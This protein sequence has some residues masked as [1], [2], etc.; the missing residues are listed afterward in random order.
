MG[1]GVAHVMSQLAKAQA[2]DRHDVTV[3][4]SVR[5]DTPMALLPT[6]FPAPI[7]LKL[8]PMVTDVA[9]LAD[10]RSLMQ[11]Y[12]LLR[13]DAPD[14]IHLHSSKAG[15]LGRLAAFVLGKRRQVFYSPHAFAFLRE[16]VSPSRQQLFLYLE[17]FGSKLGGTLIGCSQTEV[18]LARHQVGHKRTVLVENSVDLGEVLPA[19]GSTDRRVRV[20]TSGRICYQKAPWR[21]KSLAR[22]C[23][24]LPVDFAWIGNG[25]SRQELMTEGALPDKVRVTRWLSRGGV[26]AEL[27]AADVFVL[28]SLWEG[29]P[30]ALIEAQ[31]AGLPAVVSDVA[32]NRDIV[33]DGQTGFVCQTD[34][35]FLQR[36][37]QLIED[38]AL[39]DSMGRAA[40][41]MAL[42][43][44][45][46]V[47]MHRQMMAVYKSI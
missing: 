25:D 35:Q 1:A 13:L 32:G 17:R 7:R 15:F 8:V 37:R 19:I 27:A 28:P 47:R 22:G 39:R 44:F 5:P 2:A 26:Y 29:M 3:V 23:A 36:T 9:P 45:E 16:D 14:V 43:R 10:M 20:V 38:L 46:V 18:D 6:L 30:L 11:I 31:A 41:K 12:K 42:Q 34:A 4:Y 33:I 40:R 24:D 21:F